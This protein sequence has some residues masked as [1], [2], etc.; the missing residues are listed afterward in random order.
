MDSLFPLL[1]NETTPLVVQTY[2]CPTSTCVPCTSPVA[3]VS[4]LFIWTT[5][6][7]GRTVVGHR[8][9]S[10]FKSISPDRDRNENAFPGDN[11]G[12]VGQLS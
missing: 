2:K 9:R 7:S 3:S 6:T 5:T 12:Q 11:P 1:I 8:H 4:A 10:A